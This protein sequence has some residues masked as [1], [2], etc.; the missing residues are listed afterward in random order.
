M[1]GAPWYLLAG[2]ILVLIFGYCIASLK[3]GGSRRRIFITSK[4]SDEEV[5]RLLNKSQGIGV[6][7]LLMLLG[8][9][10]MFVSVVWRI[11][12]VFV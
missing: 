2:G 7:N 3:S 1:A 10:L 8:L 12:R 9:L 11:V 6:G 4:M 5:E